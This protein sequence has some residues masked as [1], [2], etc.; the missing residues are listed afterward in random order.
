MY[1]IYNIYFFNLKMYVKK[2]DVILVIRYL[3]QEI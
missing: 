2:R 3:L 1:Y